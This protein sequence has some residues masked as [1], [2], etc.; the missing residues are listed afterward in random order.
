ME[1]V[2]EDDFPESDAA[3][4]E[5]PKNPPPKN[6]DT[7]PWYKDRVVWGFFVIV[8]IIIVFVVAAI[9]YPVVQ[10]FRG[11]EDIFT[12]MINGLFIIVLML[13]IFMIVIPT[14]MKFLREDIKGRMEVKPEKWMTR[15]RTVVTVTLTLVM[16]IFV[17]TWLKT[18]E[19]LE[20]QQT[21]PNLS[22]GATNVSGNFT[23]N[24]TLATKIELHPFVKS[25]FDVYTIVIMFYFGVSGL[26]SVTDK[27]KKGNKPTTPK[28]PETT[29]K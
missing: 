19:V 21:T 29:T 9:I 13:S 5:I 26:E 4:T 11:D 17:L 7:P 28:V 16:L 1:E 24:A 6:G 3:G 15:L 22:G 23:G 2:S 18:P 12:N 14:G 20:V 10:Y 25:F 27:L 8:L